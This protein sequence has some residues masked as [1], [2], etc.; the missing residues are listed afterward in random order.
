M[1][2]GQEPPF[3]SRSP[4][5]C[6]IR[7]C[8]KSG[9]ENQD[10]EDLT[11]LSDGQMP[12]E[13][14][15]VARHSLPFVTGPAANHRELA[16]RPFVL[17]PTHLMIRNL[18]VT[19]SPTVRRGRPVPSDIGFVWLSALVGRNPTSR[20]VARYAQLRLTRFCCPI[21]VALAAC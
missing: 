7:T 5:S 2:A 6:E 15:R 4:S 12:T 11:A 17:G 9:E 1:Q 21:V 19:S 14:T 10:G 20:M 8:K 13:G 18:V 3:R 16:M